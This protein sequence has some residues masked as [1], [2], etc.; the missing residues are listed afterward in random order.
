MQGKEVQMMNTECLPKIVAMNGKR[1]RKK[2]PG[3]LC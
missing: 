1:Q 3:G 2:K